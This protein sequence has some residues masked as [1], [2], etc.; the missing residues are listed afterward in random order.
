ME[1]NTNSDYQPIA[2][3]EILE[4]Y[5]NNFPLK[6]VFKIISG[7]WKTP[8]IYAISHECP[9]RFGELK[10]KMEDVTQTTL[11]I[12]LR[13]LERDG[14]ISRQVFAESPPRVEYKLTEQGIKLL[15]VLKML[16]NWWDEYSESKKA[17]KE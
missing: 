15:P 14:I 12:Q 5:E 6:N 16:N 2:N 9:K 11:T 1:N 4:I 10:R 17:S 7:K 8:L 13:E 3:E